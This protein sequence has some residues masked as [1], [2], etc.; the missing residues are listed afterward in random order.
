MVRHHIPKGGVMESELVFERIHSFG[1]EELLNRIVELATTMQAEFHLTMGWDKNDPKQLNFSSTGGMTKGL[2]G[3]LRVE[4]DRVRMVLQLPF[5]LR[6][7]SG[8]IRQ[9]V[10]EYLNENVGHVQ[11]S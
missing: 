4:P 3:N 5:G 11:G 9:E 1:P 10:D 8:M 6:P 7:M 2:F